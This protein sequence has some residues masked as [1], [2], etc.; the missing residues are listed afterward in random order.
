M[1]KKCNC[2]SGL[3]RFEAREANRALYDI[4]SKDH[5]GFQESDVTQR[6]V[7]SAAMSSYTMV[8]SVLKAPAVLIAMAPFYQLT[9]CLR[10]QRRL[11]QMY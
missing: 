3:K 8:L 11:S 1:L 2:C 6:E 5:N 4:L 7:G 9:H 10:R